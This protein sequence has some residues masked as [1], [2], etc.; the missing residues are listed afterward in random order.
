MS[1]DKS[2]LSSFV[3]VR[4]LYITAMG[5]KETKAGRDPSSTGEKIQCRQNSDS[6]HNLTGSLNTISLKTHRKFFCG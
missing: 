4:A 3:L 5:L 6:S 1:Q 2:F